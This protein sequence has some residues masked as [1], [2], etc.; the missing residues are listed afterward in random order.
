MEVDGVS[1]S[2]LDALLK[3][4]EQKWQDSADRR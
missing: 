1:E 2:A 4:V 3:R